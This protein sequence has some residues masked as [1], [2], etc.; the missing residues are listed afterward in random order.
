MVQTNIP[1]DEMAIYLK[2]KRIL[3]EDRVHNIL[4]EIGILSY[5]SKQAISEI[6]DVFQMAC[7]PDEGEFPQ[8][9]RIIEEFVLADNELK[10]NGDVLGLLCTYQ[11]DNGMGPEEV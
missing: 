6:V 8:I 11:A 2:V 9:V 1:K 7:S 10:K 5:F 4:E 3:D